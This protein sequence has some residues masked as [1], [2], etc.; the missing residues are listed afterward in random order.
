M[1]TYNNNLQ[2]TKINYTNKMEEVSDSKPIL[3]RLVVFN[4]TTNNPWCNTIL[5]P[6]KFY[7][8]RLTALNPGI[9]ISYILFHPLKTIPIQSNY[10]L[11]DQ[12]DYNELR[13][14]YNLRAVQ[15]ASLPIGNLY[16]NLDSSCK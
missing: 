12:D 1:A 13:E 8:G 3:D 11:L 4:E 6:L 16:R 7:D 10:L 15:L 9:G 14:K 5:I 2:G